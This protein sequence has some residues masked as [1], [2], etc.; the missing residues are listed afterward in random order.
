M[1]IMPRFI[2]SREVLVKILFF[3]VEIT[4]FILILK[5]IGCV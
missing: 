1:K 4:Y 2:T 3:K 5:E